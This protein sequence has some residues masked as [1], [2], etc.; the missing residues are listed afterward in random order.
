MDADSISPSPG[1]HSPRLLKAKLPD[2][3]VAQWRTVRDRMVAAD[4]KLSPDKL[5]KNLESEDAMERIAAC[6]AVQQR[7]MEIFPSN[8]GYNGRA[9]GRIED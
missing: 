3:P 6:L 2:D 4:M 5:I 9:G 7:G 8:A 1:I